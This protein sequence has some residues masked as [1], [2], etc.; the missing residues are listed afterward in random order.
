MFKSTNIVT[1]TLYFET[2]FLKKTLYV[3][4]QYREE[5]FRQTSESTN[6]RVLWWSLAQVIVLVAMGFWQMRH[7]KT[8]FETKKLV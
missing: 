3:F 5:R 4:L 2:F 8:F 1:Y 6:K 7:L